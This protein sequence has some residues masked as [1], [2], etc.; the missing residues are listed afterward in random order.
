MAARLTGGIG[1]FEFRAIFNIVGGVPTPICPRKNRFGILPFFGKIGP[2]VVAKIFLTL[3]G[4]FLSRKFRPIYFEIG[5]SNFKIGEKFKV[6][7]L[8]GD[9]VGSDD[10]TASVVTWLVVT[11][12]VVTSL[13]V[14]ALVVTSFVVT[15]LVVSGL[16]V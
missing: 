2:V 7:I 3:G 16:G 13:V 4:A 10:V 14:T 15:S 11:P 9:V 1:E 6:A 12:L 8:P 5:L